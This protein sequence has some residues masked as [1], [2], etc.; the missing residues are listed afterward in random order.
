MTQ[1]KLVKLLVKQYRISFSMN[2]LSFKIYQ[3]SSIEFLYTDA[4]VPI[5]MNVSYAQ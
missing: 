5:T 2:P 4:A 3:E 1:P